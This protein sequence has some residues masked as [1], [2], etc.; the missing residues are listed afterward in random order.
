MV[1]K[2]WDEYKKKLLGSGHI[3]RDA[4]IGVACGVVAAVALFLH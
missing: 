4:A 2:T 3:R 1:S